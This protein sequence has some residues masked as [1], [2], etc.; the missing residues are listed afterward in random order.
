MALSKPPIRA[1]GNACC[2]KEVKFLGLATYAPD[3]VFA[4]ILCITGRERRLP[5]ICMCIPK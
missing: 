3:V 5:V 1:G 4:C 2:I